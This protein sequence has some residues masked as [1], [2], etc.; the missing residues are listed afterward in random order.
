MGPQKACATATVATLSNVNGA[1]VLDGNGVD[2]DN[3]DNDDEDDDDASAGET[4]NQE[5]FYIGSGEEQGR[6]LVKADVVRVAVVV[7]VAV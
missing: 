1:E 4:Q 6:R 2:S 3:D 7:V 5:T